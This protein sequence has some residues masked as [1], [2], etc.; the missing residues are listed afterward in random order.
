MC[1]RDGLTRRMPAMV[2]AMGRQ[3]R[4]RADL[5]VAPRIGIAQVPDR[6]AVDAWAE[7]G[8][9]Q[10]IVGTSTDDADDIARSLDHLAELVD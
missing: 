8:A 3:G 7:A 1:S 5:V 6:A 4:S 2:E 9:D 10:L